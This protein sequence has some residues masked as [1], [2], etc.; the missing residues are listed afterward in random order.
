MTLSANGKRYLKLFKQLLPLAEREEDDPEAEMQANAVRV[1]LDWLW[2][3][4]S[5]QERMWAEI[6]ALK[7]RYEEEFGKDAHDS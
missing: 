5:H 2:E 3:K 1:E 4:L 6:Q 7:D